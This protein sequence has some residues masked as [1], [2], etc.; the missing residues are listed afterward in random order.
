LELPVYPVT[1]FAVGASR[2]LITNAR[3]WRTDLEMLAL[4]A[5]V[6]AVAY[7]SGAIVAALVNG[8]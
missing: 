8:G 3:W 6:A 7:G 4:G 5:I 1:L 2:A